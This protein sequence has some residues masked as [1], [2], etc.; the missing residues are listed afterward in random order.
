MT[1][2]LTTF[3]TQHGYGFKPGSDPGTI[4]L[5]GLWMSAHTHDVFDA[6]ATIKP[7][8]DG[9]AYHSQ[10]ISGNYRLELFPASA[11]A[12]GIISGDMTDDDILS[13]VSLTERH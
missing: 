2:Q 6:D 11:D 9:T 7:I 3:L 12:D 5:T 10:D 8:C 13:P 1:Q 4:E